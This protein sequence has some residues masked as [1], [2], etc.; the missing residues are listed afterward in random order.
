M[1]T[2]RGAQD[3]NLVTERASK[4]GKARAK[5]LTPEERSE[6][7]RRAVQARWSKSKGGPQIIVSVE[8]Q[9]TPEYTTEVIK[10]GNPI[11]VTGEQSWSV[12]L[13]SSAIMLSETESYTQ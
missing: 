3:K 10:R 6:S 9:E 12:N 4:G 8:A 5:A 2:E 11:T 1:T 7:A 13:L